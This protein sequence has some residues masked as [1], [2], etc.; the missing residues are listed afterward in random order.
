MASFISSTV[1]QG[2]ENGQ[3]LFRSSSRLHEFLPTDVVSNWIWLRTSAQ[4]VGWSSQ[5]GARVDGTL[6][7]S[8]VKVPAT[9]IVADQPNL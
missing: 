6:A 8:V 3:S 5:R 7:N 1:N 9:S 4:H 2:L